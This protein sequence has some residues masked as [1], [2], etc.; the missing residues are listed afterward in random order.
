MRRGLKNNRTVAA[1]ITRLC[2]RVECRVSRAS[3]TASL[4]RLL[5][6]AVRAHLDS[7]AIAGTGESG[8]GRP[9]SK[10]WRNHEAS[11][12]TRQRFGVR[13]SSAALDF[14]AYM[15]V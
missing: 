6:C 14:A 12:L 10:T 11:R 7:A 9:H 5:Q 2:L 1:E 3:N 13:L 4:P 8:R 15:L